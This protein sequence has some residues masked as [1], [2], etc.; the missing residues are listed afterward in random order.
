MITERQNTLKFNA[1]ASHFTASGDGLSALTMTDSLATTYKADTVVD[2]ESCLCR[3]GW[4]GYLSLRGV[5]ISN[6]AWLPGRL[7]S[8]VAYS[9]SGVTGHTS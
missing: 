6:D 3:R 7:R 4:D 2:L 9:G 8:I 1:H 5:S